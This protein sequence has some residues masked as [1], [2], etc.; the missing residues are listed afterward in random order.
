MT[1]GRAPLCSRRIRSP[2]RIRR[3]A[4]KV[5]ATLRRAKRPASIGLPAAEDALWPRKVRALGDDRFDQRDDPSNSAPSPVG[6][7]P[8]KVALPRGGMG[9]P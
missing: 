3:P 5:S 4:G 2:G 7:P 1:V 6:D 9:T 8:C